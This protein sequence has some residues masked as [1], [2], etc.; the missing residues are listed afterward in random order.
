MR[1]RAF[2]S[3]SLVGSLTIPSFAR[4]LGPNDTLNLGVIGCRSMGMSDL[5]SML[6]TPGTRCVALSDIDQNVLQTRAADVFELSG[7]TP[8][9][10]GDY[11]KL[12]DNQDIDA[13]I[14]GT[15]DHWHCLQMVDAVDSGKHVYVEKPLANS[16]DECA[17][18]IRAQERTGRQVQ[19]GQ[20]QRSGK[21]WSEAIDFVQSGKLGE[22]RTVKTWAYMNWLKMDKAAD[23]PVP[24]GV[25]YDMWLGPAPVHAFN[26]N[27]FHF[28]FRW[29]WDY[30]GGLMTD[31]GVHLI[32]IA[33]WGMNATGPNRVMSS[34]GPFAYPDGGME[35]PD[36]Q[37]AIYE[38]DN[39]T[40]VWEHAVGISQGP[41]QRAHGVAFIGNNGT[42]VIDRQK[43]QIFPETELNSLDFK[44]PAQATRTA[45]PSERGL[46]QHTANFVAAIRDGEA[47]NCDIRTGSLA[48]VNAH[49]GN[50][51][52]R[53]GDTLSWDRDK[54]VFANNRAANKLLVPNYRPPWRLPA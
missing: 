10:Y 43:W 5:R 46:D 26:P 39:F 28:H 35:T 11:R 30:T 51:A 14:I 24:E 37:Q 50:I 15:P 31:W 41:F 29:F 36:T 54:Q 4:A 40:M 12:L 9:L 23:S 13:V 16:I 38:F 17:R 3:H 21:H 1:R 48:A 34:G 32:D 33:L 18:M 52:L 19:V 45:T 27:R 22:I 6:K 7:N 8:T 20:W 44:M 47:L 25:N 49:L 53:T 2:I 42:L